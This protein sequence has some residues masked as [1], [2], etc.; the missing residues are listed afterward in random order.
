MK[1]EVHGWKIT[2]DLVSRIPATTL[3][4]RQT[5]GGRIVWAS[6]QLSIHACADGIAADREFSWPF[7][8]TTADCVP[9]VLTARTTVC[10]V[11]VSRKTVLSGLLH[12]VPEF[13]PPPLITDLWIGPHI[14]AEHFVFARRGE[15]ITAFQ[16]A[17]AY[18][19]QETAAGLSLSLEAVI[20]RYIEEWGVQEKTI[21]RDNRCTYE[22]PELPSYRRALR[23]N[24]PLSDQIATVVER[25]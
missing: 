6:K 17:H 12:H 10:A 9:L 14:C 22:T 21:T 25:L 18:A 13:I 24:Q 4:V 1:V 16:Q 8:I 3:Q 23:D 7:M 2:T 19:C 5:H 11:H 15:E 20:D